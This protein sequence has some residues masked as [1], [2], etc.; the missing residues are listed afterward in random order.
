LRA[1]QHREVPAAG[2]VYVVWRVAADQP[3]FLDANLGGRFKGRDPTVSEDALRANWVDGAE[4]VYI[5]KAASLK[6]RIADFER[7]GRGAPIGHWGGRLIWQLADSVR[8]RIAW[9]PTPGLDPKRV[10]SRLI[11]EFREIYGKPPFANDPNRLGR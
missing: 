3:E 5:G 10:E 11:G 7:F 4:V 9:K 1:H 2:G 6:R 8:L